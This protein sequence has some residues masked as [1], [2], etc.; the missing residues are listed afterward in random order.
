MVSANVMAETK[1]ETAV[2]F[3]GAHE[4]H[5]FQLDV[6]KN[7]KEISGIKSSAFLSV[8]TYR[9]APSRAD[10]NQ[11]IPFLKKSFKDPKS[12]KMLVIYG[13][14]IGPDG[15]KDASSNEI[16]NF[17]LESNIKFDL[18]WFDSCFLSNIEFLFEMRKSSQYT[19]ASEEAEFSS[20]LPFESLSELPR[21]ESSEEGAVFLA[22]SFIDSYSYIKNGKQKDSVASTSATI[23]VIKNSELD[24]FIN[25]FSKVSKII[26]DLDV[27]K[28]EQLKKTLNRN[29]GMQ[30]AELVDLGHF[31]IELRKL[32]NDPVRDSQLTMLIRLLNIDSIKKLRSNP[33]IRITAPEAGAH[34]VFGFNH[35]ENG[36]QSEYLD[37]P[38]FSQILSAKTFA[39]GIN[40]R[41]W[42]VKTFTAPTTLIN[43]FAPGIESFDYYFVSADK[44][45]LL[46]K[47]TV[48]L[49]S[50]QDVVEIPRSKNT[51]GSFLIYS[52][53]TQ[54]VG[55]K[56]ER[57][58]GVNITLFE[59]VPSMDYFELEFNRLLSWLKF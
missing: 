20:G 46:T 25:Q 7:L 2:I 42:P 27:S 30:N 34:M 9:E 36:H 58:T 47:E 26:A 29:F 4:D 49:T 51:A 3:L 52:A 22:R 44:L 21:F 11:L 41:K 33:V 54:Q 18:L 23:S 39:P 38:L 56:A 5:E 48:S 35:W 12:K 1:W 6:D 13:H 24:S 15:M 50:A 57:Y 45:R 16:K 40:N 55:K 14:G 31:L 28:K 59:S 19:I 17:L 32:I 10:R 37:N 43:P 8:A 53:Y